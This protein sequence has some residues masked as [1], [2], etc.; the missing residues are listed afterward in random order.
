MSMIHD[1]RAAFS[2]F[3]GDVDNGTSPG[4]EHNLGIAD[5]QFDTFLSRLD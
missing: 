2:E 3:A 4:P 1:I 5:E